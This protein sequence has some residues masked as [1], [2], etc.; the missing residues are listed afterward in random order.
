MVVFNISPRDILTECLY[1]G[2]MTTTIYPRHQYTIIEEALGVRRIVIVSGPRQCGKTTLIKQFHSKEFEYRTLDDLALKK[3]AELDPIGFVKRSTSTMIIDEIQRVPDLILAIKQAVDESPEKG[4]YLLTGSANILSLPTV[5]ESLAGRVRKVRLRPLTQGEIELKQPNFFERAFE[6]Q[7]SGTSLYSSRDDFLEL[8]FRGGFPEIVDFNP[9]Q[10]KS[11]HLDYIEAL[12]DRDLK[13]I[14][15]IYKVDAIHTVLKVLAAWSSKYI[16]LTKV[17]GEIGIT[18]QT[19]NTYFNALEALFLV[20][21]VPTWGKTDYSRVSKKP[22]VFITDSGLLA[23][24]LDWNIDQLRLDSD[25]PGKLLE[26]FV[27]NEISAQIEISANGLKLYQYRDRA[28]REIDF[29]VE[30]SDGALLA[31]ECKAGDISRNDFKHIKWFQENLIKDRLCIGVVVY[32]GKL[33][34]SFGKNLWAIPFDFLW[35]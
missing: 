22:K 14:A 32:S 23:S 28:Q 12:I 15:T 29:I 11:W 10:R 35:N 31:I 21:R 7:F 9:R 25:R 20:E 18:R 3:A 26:T 6:Q 33:P 17:G 24:L 34:I 16:D 8:S 4:Q 5:Q 27:F 13:D 2:L 30:R 19:V 1:N